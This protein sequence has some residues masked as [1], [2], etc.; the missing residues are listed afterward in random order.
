MSKIQTEGEEETRRE[1]GEEVRG[2]TPMQT[3]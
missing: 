1:F 3:R 2:R